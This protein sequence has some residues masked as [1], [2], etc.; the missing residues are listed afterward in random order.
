[1]SDYVITCCS[2]ADM[3]KAFFEE[4]KVPYVMFHYQMDGVDYQDDLYTSV[5]PEAF[6]GKIAAGAMPVTSQVNAV[7]YTALFEAI[8]KEGKDVIHL[9]LSSGI[10]GSVNSANL[11]KQQLKEAYPDR[12]IAVID[13]LGASSGFGLLVTQALENQ[14][15]GMGFE[16]NVRW[17][18]ENK[19]RLHHW[20]FSTDL[21][22]YIRGGR[23]SKVSGFVGQA[24]KICPLLNMDNLGR[25]IPR[26]KCRGKK[27]VIREI[28]KRMEEHAENGCDYSGKCYISHSACLEDA[29]TVAAM[30][31][32]KFPKLDGRVIINP[33]GTVIGSHTGP[34]TL[35][36]FFW[37]DERTE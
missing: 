28:V 4:N 7:E 6:F 35:A 13:S 18:E 19:L 37:G 17:L 10:S 16:E 30:V 25:L 33:I 23:I 20:F 27:Q 14:K 2:T 34:G 22:S 31:E 29:E 26:T 12:K 9:A 8:L 24:L 11:A 5:T 21:T 36:L 15:A 32:E 1:M 3:S